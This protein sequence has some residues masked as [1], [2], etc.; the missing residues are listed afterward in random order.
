SSPSLPSMGFL[1]GLASIFGMGKK[2]CNIVVVG[3]DNAGKT[4]ILNALRTEDQRLSQVVPTVGMTVTTFSGAGVNFS[5]FDMSGQGKYRNLWD[6]YYAKAE[7]IMFVVDSTDR[8][9]LSVA[10]D[11]LWMILDHK[12]TRKIPL[13]IMANKSDCND[14]LPVSEVSNLLGLDLMRGRPWTIQVT[15]AITGNGIPQSMEWL[16]K[17]VREYLNGESSSGRT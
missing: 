16:S 2:S 6:A 7:G 4:T 10:R 9:R 15:S 14:A 3:L 8:L 13:L 11:E 5:A 12:D 17:N 1:S